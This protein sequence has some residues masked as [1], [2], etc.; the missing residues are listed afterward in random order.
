MLLRRLFF[1]GGATGVVL[2][3]MADNDFHCSAGPWPGA[4]GAFAGLGF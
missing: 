4:T 3:L 1:P 2:V